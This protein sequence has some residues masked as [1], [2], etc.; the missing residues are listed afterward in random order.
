MNFE[1]PS[2]AENSAQRSEQEL[3]EHR[4]K[5]K[6][7]DKLIGLLKLEIKALK[8]P[9]QNKL[10]QETLI[11]IQQVANGEADQDL[12]NIYKDWNTQDLNDLIKELR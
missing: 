7:D 8:D 4:D 11:E 3:K 1:S 9:T 10:F 12:A 2:V 5:I 6:F